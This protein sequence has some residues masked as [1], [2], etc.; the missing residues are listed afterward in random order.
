MMFPLI[1]FSPDVV[2]SGLQDQSQKNECEA[3]V[4]SCHQCRQC[5]IQVRVW[6]SP[7]QVTY[8]LQTEREGVR[9]SKKK[10]ILSLIK[11]TRVEAVL[12]LTP[13]A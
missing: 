12:R 2:D 6:I 5:G 3:I 10:V 9:T 7:E 1:A 13:F 4:E 11:L 8:R